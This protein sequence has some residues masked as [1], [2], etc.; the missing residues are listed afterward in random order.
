MLCL[1]AS[2]SAKRHA[3]GDKE[4]NVSLFALELAPLRIWLAKKK[5]IRSSRFLHILERVDLQITRRNL[6]AILP[7]ASIAPAR[8][9]TRLFLRATST[10]DPC[11]SFPRHPIFQIASQALT[12][13]LAPEPAVQVQAYPSGERV[14]HLDQVLLALPWTAPTR[15]HPQSANRPLPTWAGHLGRPLIAALFGRVPA[16]CGTFRAAPP[17]G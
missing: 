3:K 11:D 15:F 8:P 6:I 12:W 4:E 5:T 13:P 10:A 9:T 14:V 7:Q 17:I 16:R 2:L 1:K